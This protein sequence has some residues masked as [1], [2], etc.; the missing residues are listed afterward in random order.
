[1]SR[2]K[3]ADPNE[4]QEFIK[5]RPHWR[6]RFKPVDPQKDVELLQ[7]EDIVTQNRVQLRGW[8]YPH[9]SRYSDEWE[10][11]SAYVGCQ[12]TFETE[13]E[14]WR[15][16]LSHQ[17]I[18][19]IVVR[20]AIDSS[21]RDQLSRNFH[22][23][24]RGEDL[25]QVQGYI[26]IVNWLYYVSEIF[27]F[28]ARLA[29][30]SFYTGEIQIEANVTGVRNFALTTDDPGR[31]LNDVYMSKGNDASFS[32]K[33]QTTDLIT[34]SRELA[35]NETAKLFFQ[36]NWRKPALEVLRKDQAEL[37]AKANTYI[38]P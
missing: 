32:Y 36:F 21:W 18:H 38:R 7:L 31:H 23:N 15:M 13:T 9:C 33:G 1:M 4:L 2:P 16:Y 37:Y 35:L 27:E 19:L 3:P 25:T 29:T 6:I 30:A 12:S 34:S 22:I 14:Y 28:A 24:H 20:E 26:S 17:F 8:D 10:R 11:T 5:G